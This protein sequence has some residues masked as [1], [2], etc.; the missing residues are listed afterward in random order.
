MRGDI[1]CIRHK[2]TFQGWCT[3]HFNRDEGPSFCDHIAVEGW[4]ELL[5]HLPS[6]L[7]VSDLNKYDD[8][9]LYAVR[10]YRPVKFHPDKVDTMVDAAYKFVGSRYCYLAIACMGMDYLSNSRFFT[11]RFAPKMWFVCSSFVA[12]IATRHLGIAWVDVDKGNAPLCIRSVRP[13]DI[14][15]QLF[16]D[17]RF[18]MVGAGG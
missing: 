18:P 2:T 13:D 7:A 17:G 1:H 15:D 10:V 3:R 4:D 9:E 11:E 16:V 8:P 12:G 6:G 14:D 5:E